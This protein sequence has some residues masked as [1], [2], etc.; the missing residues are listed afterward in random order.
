MDCFPKKRETYSDVNSGAPLPPSINIYLDDN[1]IFCSAEI[2]AKSTSIRDYATL[3]SLK[4]TFVAF[5]SRFESAF[6]TID[7][8]LDRWV[9]KEYILPLMFKDSSNIPTEDAIYHLTNNRGLTREQWD[10]IKQQ[11]HEFRF[12]YVMCIV[13]FFFCFFFFFL[14]QLFRKNAIK[15]KHK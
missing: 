15:I 5:C 1:G 3:K 10:D 9:L 6:D 13:F 4:M 7:Q 2:V 12:A 8:M 14:S 11:C